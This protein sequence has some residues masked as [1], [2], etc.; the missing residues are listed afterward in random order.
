MPSGPLKM[1]AT[2]LTLLSAAS[3]DQILAQST[4]EA[5]LQ[6]GRLAIPFVETGNCLTLTGTLQHASGWSFGDLFFFFDMI[7]PEEGS[8]DIY[9]EAYVNFSLGKI[10]N[11]DVSFGP[12]QDIGL[13][14]G[15]NWAADANVRK[16]LPGARLSW[17]IPGFLFLNTD[18]TAYLDGSGGVSSGGAPSES[19]SFMTDGNWSYPFNI[20]D[21]SFGIEGHI[22]YIGSRVN[23]FGDDV[24][25]WILGQPQLRLDLGKLLY[26]RLGQLFIGTE[27]QFWINKLGD[28]STDESAFQA[29]AVW[30]F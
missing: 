4:T 19:N 5:H 3:A 30:R 12:I 2:S 7:D 21:V 6:Y 26:N 8:F 20:G 11:L 28:P 16:Y 22:E 17:D 9:G 18:I 14:F 10:T 13:I 1:L 25:W 27:Y 24:S 23:E 15:F 29:L